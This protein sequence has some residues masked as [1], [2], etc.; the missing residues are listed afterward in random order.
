MQKVIVQVPMSK[1]LRDSA[2]AV[3]QEYGFSSLQEALRVIATKLS[4]RDLNIHIGEKVE[5]LTP[6]EEKL[7][8]NMYKEFL[9][10]EKAGKTFTA[11]SI[12]EMMK[13][14]TL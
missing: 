2:Q 5:Y 8:E 7:L 6:K 13:D 1:K 3:A 9:E 10:D 12:D 4:K 14:L 11:H